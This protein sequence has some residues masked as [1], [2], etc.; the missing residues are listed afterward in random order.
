[1]SNTDTQGSTVIVGATGTIATDIARKLTAQGQSLLLIARNSEKLSRLAA[2]LQQPCVCSSI[3]SSAVLEEA[4][5]SSS[6]QPPRA[7]VNCIGSV[8][9]KSAHATSDDEF[10]QTLETNLFTSCACVKVAGNLF[11]TTAGSVITCAT[12]PAEIRI[13]TH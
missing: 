12:A 4:I 2:E 11:R 6:P 7:I 9:L 1:M 8:L 10:R 3:E 5:R 13:A